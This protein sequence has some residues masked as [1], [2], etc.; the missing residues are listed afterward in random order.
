VEPE[1]TAPDAEL[2]SGEFG[3]DRVAD[4]E[5]AVTLPQV[6]AAVER[7]R[8]EMELVVAAAHMERLEKQ[9]ANETFRSKAPAHVIEGMETTLGETRQRVDGLRDRIGA[10]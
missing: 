1:V 6:D 9:L 10:L 5:V 7:A 3:F 2:P 8:L 4:T